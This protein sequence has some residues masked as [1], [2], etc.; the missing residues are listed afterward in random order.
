MEKKLIFQQV[1]G[2]VRT[3]PMGIFLMCTSYRAVV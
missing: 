1:C 2:F 3:L